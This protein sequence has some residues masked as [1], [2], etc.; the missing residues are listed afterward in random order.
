MKASLV[1][2]TCGRGRD[3]PALVSAEAAVIMME[4]TSWP[5]MT[6]SNDLRLPCL[7]LAMRKRS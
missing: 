4:P 3:P 2:P 7:V 5:Q 1:S 6:G